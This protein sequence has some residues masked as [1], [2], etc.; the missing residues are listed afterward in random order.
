MKTTQSLLLGMVL[1]LAG[2]NPKL[3]APSL[4][5]LPQA[6]LTAFEQNGLKTQ[7]T[8]NPALNPFYLQG[9]FDG[10][11]APDYAV[12][13][14]NKRT[15]KTAVAFLL[16]TDPAKAMVVEE[17]QWP[18]LRSFM[19]VAFWKTTSHF[20]AGAGSVLPGIKGGGIVL[21]LRKP[22]EVRWIYWN[23]QEWQCINP[24]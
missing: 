2:C 21:G 10:D 11:N 17:G 6:L 20:P 24:E 22:E 14:Q 1:M 13:L 18:A 5:Y 8:L 3:T 16:G 4:D 19:E 12:F 23:G 15:Q 7:Y 9:N